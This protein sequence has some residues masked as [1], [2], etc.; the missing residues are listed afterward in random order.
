MQDALSSFLVLDKKKMRDVLGPTTQAFLI[1]AVNTKC[2]HLPVDAVIE[3]EE[4]AKDEEG[5]PVY[6]EWYVFK[7][8]L[9]I[10]VLNNKITIERKVPKE[11]MDGR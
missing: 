5:N 7:M 11:K 10:P 8:D 9:Y 4:I 1:E 2:Y 6:R 3:K